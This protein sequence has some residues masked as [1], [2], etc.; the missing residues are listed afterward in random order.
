MKRKAKPAIALYNWNKI[1]VTGICAKQGV[2]L[3]NTLSL[4]CRKIE[5]FA[6]ELMQSV[7]GSSRRRCIT[8]RRAEKRRWNLNSIL[9][10]GIRLIHMFCNS[11]SSLFLF[12]SLCLEWFPD[13]TGSNTESKLIAFTFVTCALPPN[14]LVPLFCLLSIDTP[15]WASNLSWK[16]NQRFQW[17]W[18]LIFRIK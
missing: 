11:T 5:Q 16:I 18:K 8:K 1:V 10:F 2:D 7:F 13:N 9:K 15:Y 4:I 6:L 3:C 14:L 17:P 12:A